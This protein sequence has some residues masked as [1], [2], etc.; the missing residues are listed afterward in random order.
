MITTIQDTQ[1]SAGLRKDCIH[2]KTCFLHHFDEEVGKDLSYYTGKFRDRS[3]SKKQA[4][5]VSLLDATDF[6]RVP[7]KGDGHC[8][9][10]A[11]L[12]A[13]ENKGT[14]APTKQTLLDQVKTSLQTDLD[15]L[16]PYIKSGT[17]PIDEIDAYINNANYNSSIVDLVIPVLLN[18]LGVGIIVLQPDACETKYVANPNLMYPSPDAISGDH[19]YL[20]KDGSHYDPLHVNPSAKPTVVTLDDVPEVN[21]DHAV[22]AQVTIDDVPISVTKPVSTGTKHT[23]PEATREDE[24]VSAEDTELNSERI[25]AALCA[26]AP[27]YEVRDCLRKNSFE[28]SLKRQK[29]IFNQVNKPI[30]MKYADYLSVHTENLVKGE[31][32]HLLN[33]LP[34]TCQICKERYVCNVNDPPFLACHVCG[35]EVHKPCFIAKLGLKD[36]E[37]FDINTMINPLKLPGIHYLCAEC[38]VQ[39]IPAEEISNVLSSTQKPEGS[40][41]AS[42]CTKPNETPTVSADFL[43]KDLPPPMSLDL[44]DLSSTQRSTHSLVVS[45]PA[46]DPDLK[47]RKPKQKICVYYRNNRC[48]HGMKGKECSFIHPERCKKLMQHG[49]KQ[50]DGCNLGRKCSFFHPKMCPSSITKRTCY[51]EKCQLAH[52]KGTK[53]KP[54]LNESRNEVKITNE[55]KSRKVSSAVDS[56][57]SAQPSNSGNPTKPNEDSSN[58][59]ASSFLEAIRLLKQ[60]LC[61]AMDKKIAMSL[62]QM[63]HYYPRVQ[64][65]PYHPLP[66]QLQMPTYPTL[67]P[68][69]QQQYL[70]RTNPQ[71]QPQMQA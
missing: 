52:V 9:I 21:I 53:K 39:T 45:H 32:V 5:S 30:L 50:P 57:T 69:N 18:I 56:I 29:S 62:S 35:Q 14:E 67:P 6:T 31:I 22:A 70:P 49:T 16:S 40:Q 59:N 3:K 55:D 7:V 11:V 28:K 36:T 23:I 58:S 17:D 4:S 68:F 63:S 46:V 60:E 24:V 44:S 13:V 38:E 26:N 8:I 65:A 41:L 71:F 15:S 25:L 1:C 66:F 61:E 10:H 48:R 12:S 64:N 20:I 34:D 2:R 19:I 54:P 42:V 43:L 33:L 51:D 27:D 47:T 37:N